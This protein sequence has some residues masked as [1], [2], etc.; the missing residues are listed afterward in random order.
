MGKGNIF[1][2]LS[3]RLSITKIVVLTNKTVEYFL[4]TSSAYLF[5]LDRKQLANRTLNRCL[6]N[7]YLGWFLSIGQR[8]GWGRFAGR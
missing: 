5:K 3:N 7:D 6:V 2:M 8:I 4:K 1:E